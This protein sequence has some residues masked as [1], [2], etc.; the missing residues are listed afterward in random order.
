MMEDTVGDVNMDISDGDTSDNVIEETDQE[1]EAEETNGDGGDNNE[2]P[3]E[4]GQEDEGSNDQSG[5]GDAIRRIQGIGKVLEGRC[6]QTKRQRT[7]SFSKRRKTIINSGIMLHIETNANVS[8]VLESESGRRHVFETNP[9]QRQQRSFAVQVG[10]TSVPR[11]PPRL[12]SKV[13]TPTKTPR[14]Q[15]ST[16]QRTVTPPVTP[17]VHSLPGK[18][19]KSVKAAAKSPNQNRCYACGVIYGSR[20]DLNVKKPKD[21]KPLGL[22]VTKKIATSGPMPP[23]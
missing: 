22:D 20:K 2:M 16:S 4:T 6:F 7:Q 3:V 1:S 15:G 9:K 23:V 11:H 8:I 19:K 13:N 5:K 14:R 21:Y 12:R 10:E 18:Q 17:R